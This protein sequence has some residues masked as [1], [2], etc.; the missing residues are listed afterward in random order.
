M[1][2]GTEMPDVVFRVV[3][4]LFWLWLII[5]IAANRWQVSRHL[6]R[7]AVVIRAWRRADS[8]TG[9][10][11]LALSICT[12]VLTVDVVLNALWP[13]AIADALGIKA[14]RTRRDSSCRLGSG[15]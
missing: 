11:E 4:P 15:S 13:G 1:S 9:Y 5:G 2:E 10:L 8:P 12:L 14:L 6:G 3:L 7:D